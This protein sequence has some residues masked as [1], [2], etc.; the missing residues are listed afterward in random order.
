MAHSRRKL[1]IIGHTTAESEK[2]DKQN[3]NRQLR[4]VN[5]QILHAD[6][7]DERLKN[8]KAVSDRRY[9]AKDGKGWLRWITH[10]DLHLL[11]K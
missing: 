7:E 1:P 9:M 10:Q 11:R 5:R 6:G 4:R 3:Y 8:V 2:E